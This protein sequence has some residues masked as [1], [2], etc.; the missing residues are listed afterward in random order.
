[1]RSRC[2]FVPVLAALL[3]LSAGAPALAA[4]EQVSAPVHLTFRLFARGVSDLQVSGRYLSFAQTTSTKQRTFER[5]RLLDDRTGKRIVTPRGCDVGAL[6]DPWVGLD[7][8]S[9]LPDQSYEA[10]DLRT[11]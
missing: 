3:A 10:F 2:V 4:S 11:K 5:S 9:G 8:D 1:M 7:C 6:G